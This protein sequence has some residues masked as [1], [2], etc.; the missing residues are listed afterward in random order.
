MAVQGALR[1]YQ[2]HNEGQ[3]EG[4]WLVL[5]RQYDNGQEEG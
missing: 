5:V 2:V 4:M 1:D 3:K